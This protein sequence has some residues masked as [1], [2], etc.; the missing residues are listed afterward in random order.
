MTKAEAIAKINAEINQM[1]MEGDCAAGS[2]HVM[3]F[4][5]A[6]DYAM[7]HGDDHVMVKIDT[8]VTFGLDLVR[9]ALGR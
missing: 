1:N 4:G 8:E 5:P 7:E 9:Q 2:F 3:D 6:Y